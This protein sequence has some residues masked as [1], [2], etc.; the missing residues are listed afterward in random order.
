MTPPLTP[1]AP[2]PNS[3]PAQTVGPFHG[4]ALPFADGGA[5][6]PS[7]HPRT[8]TVHGTVLDGAG[9]PVPHALLE[10]WQTG[11]DGSAPAVPGSLR[12]DGLGF[13]GFARVTTGRDGHYLL[14]TLPPGGAPYLA[15]CLFA[16]GL[17]HH[18]FTRLYFTLPTHDPLLAAL[19]AD[20]RPTLLATPDPGHHR[21]YRFD[22][23]L[24]GDRETVFLD[25]TE[26]PSR[27][28]AGHGDV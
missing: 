10:F 24:Q 8:V 6:A 16:R 17:P 18:L 13:T 23:R 5:P 3:T 19:P 12:R 20:R 27:P 21:A 26:P 11:P 22:I 14:R 9:A 4:H 25:F 1:A 7:G 28:D 15:V 2:A